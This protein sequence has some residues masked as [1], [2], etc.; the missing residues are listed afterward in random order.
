MTSAFSPDCSNCAA[1]CCLA[2]AFDQGDMFGHDKAAG[3]PCHNLDGF[4]CSIHPQLADK[5]YHG[6]VAFDCLGAGQRVTALFDETWREAPKRTAPMIEAFRVMREVQSLH[7]ML[8]A[9]SALPLPDD[10]RAEL[11]GRIEDL[12]QIKTELAMLAQFDPSEAKRW[13]RSLAPFVKPAA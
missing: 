4:A 12:E 8:L 7:Q 13:L 1:L 5:G 3:M 11:R 6:C 2:L 10:K 9:A